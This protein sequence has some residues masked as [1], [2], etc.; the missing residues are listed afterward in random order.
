MKIE[1][2]FKFENGQLVPFNSIMESY[3]IENLKEGDVLSGDL[4]INNRR[5]LRTKLQNS[6]MWLFNTRVAKALNDAGY[7]MKNFFNESH[8]VS[9]SETSVKEHI[10]NTFSSALHGTEKS[11]KLDT[12]QFCEVGEEMGAR[13]AASKGISVA[14]PS[15]DELM[16]EQDNGKAK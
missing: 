7:D 6:A 9:F 4:T 14:W 3:F 2:A 13:L 11:S 8:T 15:R 10:W 1:A 5:G 16:M 12:K